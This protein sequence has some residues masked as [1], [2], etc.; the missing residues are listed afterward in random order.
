M[1]NILFG[2]IKIKVEKEILT[3]RD[4][5]FCEGDKI[6]KPYKNTFKSP[7]QIIEVINSKVI[8]KTNN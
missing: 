6:Y 4:A 1:K 7:A 8:G 3:I 2:E 5:V